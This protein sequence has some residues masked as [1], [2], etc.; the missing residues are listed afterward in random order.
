MTEDTE[1]LHAFI[2]SHGPELGRA[3]R[4]GQLSQA[5]MG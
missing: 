4:V 3:R 2:D 1:E 5:S